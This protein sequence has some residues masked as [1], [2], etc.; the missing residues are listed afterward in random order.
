MTESPP[1][2]EQEQGTQVQG[3]G[4][5]NIVEGLTTKEHMCR[6]KEQLV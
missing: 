3:V 6:Y 4:T 1:D 5:G 2:P